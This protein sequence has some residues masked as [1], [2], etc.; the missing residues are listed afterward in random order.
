MTGFIQCAV[1]TSLLGAITG[2]AAPSIF[3]TVEQTDTGNVCFRIRARHIRNLF[4]FKVRGIRTVSIWTNPDC[5]TVWFLDASLGETRIRLLNIEYGHI[6]DCMY[7]AFP[8]NSVVP[9]KLRSGEIVI[10]TIT[11]R[12]DSFVPCSTTSEYAYQ[13]TDEGWV[14]LVDYDIKYSATIEPVD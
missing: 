5:E 3:L 12:Y 2:C 13:I 9:R 11:G 4:K 10:V 7:Q 14:P 8:S 6:P 1:I